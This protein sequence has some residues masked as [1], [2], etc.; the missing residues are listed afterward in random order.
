MHFVVVF[1][2]LCFFTTCFNV[3][4]T[5]LLGLDW[6]PATLVSVICNAPTAIWICRHRRADA[7]KIAWIIQ[8]QRSKRC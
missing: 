8:N 2:K 4:V 3:S 1:L 7:D 5:W 6:F